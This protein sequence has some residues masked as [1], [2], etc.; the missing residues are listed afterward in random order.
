MPRTKQKQPQRRKHYSGITKRLDRSFK[1]AGKVS[2]KIQCR[3]INLGTK[4]TLCLLSFVCLSRLFSKKPFRCL[5]P[6]SRPFCLLGTHDLCPHHRLFLGWTVKSPSTF[7]ANPS[8]SANPPRCPPTRT[9]LFF[10]H[11][12][13]YRDRLQA[14][15]RYFEAR[16]WKIIGTQVPVHDPERKRLTQVRCQSIA[17]P[18]AFLM[19]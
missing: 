13:I 19:P 11:W 3:A 4:Y 1:V 16:K 7:N 8:T 2:R 17:V 14:I 5:S 9:A 18:R 15:I 6:R 12:L 10:L